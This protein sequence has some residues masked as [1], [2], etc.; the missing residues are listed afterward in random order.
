[1]HPS[2][3]EVHVHHF[4]LWPIFPPFPH[5]SFSIQRWTLPY[6]TALAVRGHDRCFNE[7]LEKATRLV[8]VSQCFSPPV[9][10]PLAQFKH[11]K[12]TVRLMVSR[13]YWEPPNGTQ[14]LGSMQK[15]EV[16][17]SSVLGSPCTQRRDDTF[18][19]KLFIR[20]F[21]GQIITASRHI[22]IGSPGG[23]YIN[24]LRREGDPGT[25]SISRRWDNWLGR[26]E[27]SGTFPKAGRE[28]P[29]WGSLTTMLICC[30]T[31]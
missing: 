30:S 12:T 18:F 21:W 4:K 24:W 16:Y 31:V 10:L 2:I 28:V 13:S 1:V 29:S 19:H 6:R 27:D 23:L 17:F 20:F 5:C 8:G 26:E 14:E 9:S 15:Q 3:V 11:S 7:Y 22:M 25:F